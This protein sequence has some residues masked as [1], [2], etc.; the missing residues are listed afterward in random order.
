MIARASFVV[1]L[2]LLAAACGNKERSEPTPAAN[3]DEHFINKDLAPLLAQVEAAIP[4][5]IKAQVELTRAPGTDAQRQA[6]AT[7]RAY[8]AGFLVGASKLSPPTAWKSSLDSLVAIVTKLAEQTDQLELT[9]RQD[10]ELKKAASA[11]GDTLKSYADWKTALTN[12]LASAHIAQAPLPPPPEPTTKPP[13]DNTPHPCGGPCPCTDISIER[14]GNVITAC[15]LSRDY[16]VSNIYCAAGKVLFDENTGELSECV[17]AALFPPFAIETPGT[18]KDRVPVCGAG[19]V[20]KA[21]G[22]VT[23][24]ILDAELTIGPDGATTKVT[25]PARVFFSEAKKVSRAVMPD[26]KQTCFDDAE[27]VTNC[28]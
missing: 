27:K 4:P 13:I 26:G 23:S 25:K 5:L 11:L 21:N 20:T 19:P 10:A 3:A 28:N 24:C 6:L 16:S 9:W 17:A 14:K 18:P 22:A 7:A 1:G 15:T 8:L 2:A 12:G